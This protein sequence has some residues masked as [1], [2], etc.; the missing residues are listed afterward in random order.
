MDANSRGKT[1]RRFSQDVIEEVAAPISKKRKGLRKPSA[2]KMFKG[3][4]NK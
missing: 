2:D 3:A 1:Q 4:E